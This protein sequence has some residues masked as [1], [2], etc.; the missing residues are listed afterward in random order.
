[1]PSSACKKKTDANRMNVE[2][3]GRKQGFTQQ[4]MLIKRDSLIVQKF[5]YE[6]VEELRAFLFAGVFFFLMIRRPPRSTLF[7]YTTLFR[8]RRQHRREPG[9]E[10]ARRADRTRD[11]R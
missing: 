11:V 4:F 8:S 7:P 1:M 9:D 3:G 6:W 10:H 5:V 2:I